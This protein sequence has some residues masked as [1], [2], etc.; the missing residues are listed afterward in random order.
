MTKFLRK[1]QSNDRD[2]REEA[3]KCRSSPF[4]PV[5]RPWALIALLDSSAIVYCFIG[6]A[7]CLGSF[8]TVTRVT[9]AGRDFLHSGPQMTPKSVDGRSI[10]QSSLTGRTTLLRSHRPPIRHLMLQV[11]RM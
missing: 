11:V 2:V 6:H 4:L 9:I 10:S 7:D 8:N 1:H 3:E 5:A